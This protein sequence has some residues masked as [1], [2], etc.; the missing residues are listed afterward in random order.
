M[1]KRCRGASVFRQIPRAT[2]IKNKTIQ[3][4]TGE[5]RKNVFI[6]GSIKN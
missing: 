2:S 5:E 4:K 3:N 6:L 1:P